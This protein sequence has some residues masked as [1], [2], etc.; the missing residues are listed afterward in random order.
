M[1]SSL[2]LPDKS[3]PM[4]DAWEIRE[5][6][7]HELDLVIDGGF[8]GVD[9]TAVVDLTEQPPRLVRQGKQDDYHL[10]DLLA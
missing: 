5:T 10:E 1:S 4:S 6:L 2:I 9:P 3:T 7:E 8:C